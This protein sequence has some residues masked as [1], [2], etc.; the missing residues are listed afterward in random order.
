MAQ[1]VQKHGGSAAVS[2][3][4][5]T[6]L[7]AVGGRKPHSIAALAKLMGTTTDCLLAGESSVANEAHGATD[8]TLPDNPIDHLAQALHQLD[9][10]ARERA[11]VLLQGLARD[12]DGPLGG[13]AYRIAGT[14]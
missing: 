7:E 9:A 8:A 1:E 14:V 5:I 4:A 6:Q 10:P 12:P 2:G 13:V 3:Q 11:A